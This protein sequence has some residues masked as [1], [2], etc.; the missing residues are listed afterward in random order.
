LKL[1]TPAAT[2]HRNVAT[3][4][5]YEELRLLAE[6]T[7]VREQLQYRVQPVSVITSLYTTIPR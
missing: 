4:R 6:L 3:L 5:S 2:K 1:H 7:H